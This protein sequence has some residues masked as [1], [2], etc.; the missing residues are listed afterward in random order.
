MA[1]EL[2][3]PAVNVSK[4]TVAGSMVPSSSVSLSVKFKTATPSSIIEVESLTASE[5]SFTELTTINKV[6]FT[7]MF[8]VGEPSSQI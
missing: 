4:S 3:I 1:I 7:Q 8:G 6:S 5:P 2:W